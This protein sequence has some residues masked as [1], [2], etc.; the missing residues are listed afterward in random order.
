[1]I[2][3]KDDTTYG[4]KGRAVEVVDA[5]GQ[6]NSGA[7]LGVT[8]VAVGG[9]VHVVRHCGWQRFVETVYRSRGGGCMMEAI[10]DLM[11]RFENGCS[12]SRGP[13][14]AVLI[15]PNGSRPIHRLQLSSQSYQATF[16]RNKI[17]SFVFHRKL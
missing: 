1:M 5:R 11:D 6:G 7:G 10:A 4:T 16:S 2:E 14:V 17:L 13:V 9:V 12:D 3:N 8:V 15:Y